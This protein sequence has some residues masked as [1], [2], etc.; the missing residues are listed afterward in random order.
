MHFKKVKAVFLFH[1]SEGVCGDLR[2][3]R[4]FTDR[5]E[6]NGQCPDEELILSQGDNM[7]GVVVSNVTNATAPPE[8]VNPFKPDILGPKYLPYII[9][10]LSAPFV[11]FTVFFLYGRYRKMIERMKTFN[12][13]G[14][15]DPD[16]AKGDFTKLKRVLDYSFPS[17]ATW[18][19]R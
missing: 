5:V 17:H 8:R 18:I 16:V 11:V 1:N 10:S 12:E 6:I 19:S 7:L 3:A 14:M 13:D 2:Y 4:P 9:A 15:A